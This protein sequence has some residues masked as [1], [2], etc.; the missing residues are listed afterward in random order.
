MA[1]VGLFLLLLAAQ[2]SASFSISCAVD[3]VTFMN[4]W[5][6]ER[7]TDCE[8]SVDVCDCP[9][10]APLEGEAC[11]YGKPGCAS[12][13]T[14]VRPTCENNVQEYVMPDGTVTQVTM[15][16]PWLQWSWGT[17]Q[18]QGSSDT[19]R[20]A[21]RQATDA[22]DTIGDHLTDVISA[23]YGCQF[24]D[25]TIP[26]GSNHQPDDCTWCYCEAAGQR[27][28]CAIQDCA[29]PPCSNPEHVPGQCCPVCSQ[30]D[31]LWPWHDLM[32]G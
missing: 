15:A 17:C 31:F 2:R 22:V 30:V 16:C 29:P 5:C 19:R 3:P 10:C 32:D 8:L 7:P 14:C 24:G 27:P 1:V 28:M 25:V 26:V 9:V 12:G 4:N 11:F 20:G 13:L 18:S 23:M 6:P 21:K